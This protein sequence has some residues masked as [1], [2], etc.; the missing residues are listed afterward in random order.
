MTVKVT[1]GVVSGVDP[2]KVAT[3]TTSDPLYTGMAGMVKTPTY[4]PLLS[5]RVSVTI[6]EYICI[7]NLLTC[8]L[9]KASCRT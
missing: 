4:V 5:R 2:I 8:Q 1:G 3:Q 6:S 7:G 9:I